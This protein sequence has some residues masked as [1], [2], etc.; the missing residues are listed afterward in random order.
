MTAPSDAPV[1]V[2]GA[3]GFLG[4]AVVQ[5][6]RE[7]GVA[8]RAAAGPRSR[9]PGI[10]LVIDVRDAADVAL[11]MTGVRAVIHLAAVG[12]GR[13]A[14]DPAL[15]AA[16]NVAGTHHIARAAV[17]AS[18]PRLLL[19]STHAVYADQ[20]G[21]LAESAAVAPASSYAASKLAAEQLAT[22]L[23]RGTG[24]QTSVLR[25]FNLHGPGAPDE[26]IVERFRSAVV[27]GRPVQILGRPTRAID[28]LRVEE[29]AAAIVALVAAEQVP[30]R[31][32]IGSGVPTPL[33]ALAQAVA[34]AEGRTVQILS[35]D[36]PTAPAHDRVADIRRL[37]ACWPGFHARPLAEAIQT[38]VAA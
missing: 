17:R 22:R 24:T 18:V 6:L 21:P 36:D 2:T 13:A 28:L 16:V 30:P 26:N 8:V 19:A 12:G 9:G 7:A 1:L 20:R 3:A 5:A 10:D 23:T 25:L 4:R 33:G 32:N 27:E 14:A 31:L 34:D 15:A 29:A 11:A 37:A 38:A 35:T